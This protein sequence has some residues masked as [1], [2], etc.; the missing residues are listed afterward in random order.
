MLQ[1][2]QE[3]GNEAVNFVVKTLSWGPKLSIDIIVQW[4]PTMMTSIDGSVRTSSIIEG[5]EVNLWLYVQL[6]KKQQQ[7]NPF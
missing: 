6:I 7:K 4:I 1:Q 2:M 3:I 5:N